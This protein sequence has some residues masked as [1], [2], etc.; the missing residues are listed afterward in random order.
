M[1]GEV[2]LASLFESNC[3]PDTF[4]ISVAGAVDEIK[5]CIISNIVV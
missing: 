2:A 4:I 5:E 1:T 3:G